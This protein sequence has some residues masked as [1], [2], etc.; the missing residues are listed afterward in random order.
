MLIDEAAIA[1]EK[2]TN[3]MCHWNGASQFYASPECTEH[4]YHPEVV[5]NCDRRPHNG[6]AW[7]TGEDCFNCQ[8][9]KNRGV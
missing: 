1:E 4:C 7:I 3:V 5:K 2:E 9:V 6:A 8:F